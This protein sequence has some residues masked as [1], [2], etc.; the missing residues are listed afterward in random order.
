M[1]RQR[2]SVIRT[3]P[4]TAHSHFSII[5]RGQSQR[6]LRYV[7]DARPGTAAIGDAATVKVVAGTAG[8]L[9]IPPIALIDVL[10]IQLVV[11]RRGR[12]VNFVSRLQH[13]RHFSL[14]QLK[15]LL[16]DTVGEKAFRVQ[17]QNRHS[18]QST[19]P[20]FFRMV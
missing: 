19:V 17:R 13:R 9:P 16:S 2:P 3:A 10:I 11:I 20:A 8:P 7:P 1:L 5:E 15:V 4:R 12:H 6:A 14:R 18:R